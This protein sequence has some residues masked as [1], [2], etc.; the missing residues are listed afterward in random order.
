MVPPTGIYG[1]FFLL[2]VNC[3]IKWVVLPCSGHPFNSIFFCFQKQI[4]QFFCI[5]FC[6]I[7][8]NKITAFPL[9]FEKK[10]Q[11]SSP[12]FLV[13]FAHSATVGKFFFSKTNLEWDRLVIDLKVPSE[14]T[15]S[16]W[17]A[18]TS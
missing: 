12:F 6:P 17:S 10:D 8:Q 1:S 4:G 7:E 9:I 3:C 13:P 16:L 15:K 18:R 11:R 14:K 5:F 2:Q